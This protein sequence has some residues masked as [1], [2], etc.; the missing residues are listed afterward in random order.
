MSLKIKGKWSLMWCDVEV[1]WCASNLTDGHGRYVKGGCM[2]CSSNMWRNR[3]G[4]Q[5]A[6]IS[7]STHGD[8]AENQGEVKFEVVWRGGGEVCLR[9]DWWT[10]WI[11][12]WRCILCSSSMWRNRLGTQPSHVFNSTQ[13][14]IVENQRE[15]KFEV[16]CCLGVDVCLRSDRRTW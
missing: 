9:S 7:K 10:W 15:V 11:Y 14:Y 13:G 2:F 16:V 5:P 4:T 3:L 12:A 8:I 1:E 6:R